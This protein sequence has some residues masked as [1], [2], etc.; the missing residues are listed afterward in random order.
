MSYIIPW[1]V[2]KGTSTLTEKGIYEG[3]ISHITFFQKLF[4]G[5]DAV[6]AT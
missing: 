3:S 4:T 6:I 2:R 1:E 5:K